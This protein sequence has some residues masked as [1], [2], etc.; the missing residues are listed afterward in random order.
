M[1]LFAVYHSTELGSGI[2]SAR[3]VELEVAGYIDLEAQERNLD[4]KIEI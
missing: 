2:L 4:G 1:P 3:E